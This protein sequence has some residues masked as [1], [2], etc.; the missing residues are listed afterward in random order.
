MVAICPSV[1][2]TDGP[3]LSIC[4]ATFQDI[5]SV[6]G[7]RRRRVAGRGGQSFGE[8][9]VALPHS[10]PRSLAPGQSLGAQ[11]KLDESWKLH[12]LHLINDA[13]RPPQCTRSLAPKHTLHCNF[14]REGAS[15][16][17]S[18]RN[19]GLSRRG[20]QMMKAKQPAAAA[21]LALGYDC[22]EKVKAG[23]RKGVITTG[24]V[25]LSFNLDAITRH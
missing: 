6:G 21:A 3:R 4:R 20:N 12:G 23:D 16:I 10:L 14:G 25:P 15:P 8:E 7:L 13:A 24:G 9:G 5:K 19:C 17:W 22:Y 1:R 2:L 18:R 11:L